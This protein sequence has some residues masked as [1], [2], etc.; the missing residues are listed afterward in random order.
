MVS[1]SGIRG[2]VGESITPE[3]AVRYAS[4]FGEYCLKRSSAIPTVVIG[5]DG[6]VTGKY[7][8]DLIVSTLRAKGVHVRDLGVCPTPTVQLAVERTGASGG[9]VIT[10][11]HNP[12]QGN[13]MKFVA[14]TGMFIDG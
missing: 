11:S 6:R 2:I 13:G 3:V 8:T 7:L 9:I 5:R 12:S 1:I 4:A 10:A 14:S